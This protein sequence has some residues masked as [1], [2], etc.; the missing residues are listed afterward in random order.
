[1]GAKADL[2]GKDLIKL[3]YPEGP[4]VGLAMDIIQKHFKRIS[5]EEALDLLTQVLHNPGEFSEHPHW[6]KVVSKLQPEKQAENPTISLLEQPLPFPVYGPDQIEA[7]A[8]SQMT[9]AMRLPVSRAGALMPDAH[10]GYGLPIG[11]VLA[12]ENAVIPYGVGMDIGCRMCMSIFDLPPD[13]AIA[14]KN[15]FKNLLSEHTRFGIDAFDRPMDDPILERAEFQ[16]IPLLRRLKDKAWSQIGTSG[17]GNHFVEFGSV[18]IAD[19]ENPLGL[20]PGRYLALLSHSGSRG[21][22]ANIAQ[23]YTKLA[24]ELCPLPQKAQHLAWLDLDTEAGQEYWKAMNLAGD[25]ASACHHQ[26]HYR[27]AKALK[28][29]TLS[30]IENHH[31]FAWEMEL[32]KGKTH[33]VH[34]KGATPAGKGELG[35]IPGSM[36]APAFIVEG[37]GNP[38]S[39]YSAAHGAGRKMSR[40]QATQ[41]F[42]EHQ[43]RKYLQEHD[44]ELIGGGLDESPFAY[45]DIFQV[46]ESQRDLVRPIAAFYPRIVRMDG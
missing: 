40:R 17:S 16:E 20:A 36:T 28:A 1:M 24:M 15:A 27:I 38:L 29:E 21:L 42:T 12:V 4:A 44:V 39:L 9:M 43:L 32:A 35:V 19:A 13:T 10:A 7:E 25:Y 26:I 6:K 34:R 8:T 31:N 37:K 14:R 45:K 2:R 3:G 33:I 5:R 11:G 46:M 41:S 30:R 22:G 18:E 23:H